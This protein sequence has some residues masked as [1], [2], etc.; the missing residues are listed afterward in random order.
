[1]RAVLDP[2]VLV[3]AVLSRA[4]APAQLLRAWI[5]GRF[6]LVISAELLD[7]LTR[8]LA[9]PKIS[10]R[11]AAADAA[12]FLALL[13]MR[14]TSA[15]DPEDAPAVRCADPDDDYL[16]ALAQGSRAHLVTGDTALLDLAGRIPVLSPRAFLAMIEP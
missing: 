15:P 9:Y 4:G 13:R 12:A 6:E 2:N 1:M 7:E 5:G 8:V 14:A 16:I 3:S 10:R 11:I